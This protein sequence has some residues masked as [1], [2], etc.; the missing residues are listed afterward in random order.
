V[1]NQKPPKCAGWSSARFIS[2]DLLTKQD[3]C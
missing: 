1:D 3:L 2:L